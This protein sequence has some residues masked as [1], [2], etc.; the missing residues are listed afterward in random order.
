MNKPMITFGILG[1]GMI[2]DFHAR[3]IA[4]LPDATLR[5]VADHAPER[6]ANFAKSHGARAYEDYAAM[7]ADDAI[8][9]ICICTPSGHHAENA[10][11]ALRA[12]KHVVL[13]KPMALNAADAARVTAECKARGLFLTVISQ[14]RFSEDVQRIRALVGEGAFG[15][16]IFCGLS[17]KYWRD[18]DYY[19]NS[20]WKGTL[21]LDGGGALINQGI[22]GVDLMLH[23]MGDATVAG[24]D[25]RTL[26][27][28]IEAEDFCLALL[29]FDNGAL[30]RIEAASCAY[31]GFQR[32]LE[33]IG[34]EGCA[35]LRENRIEKLVVHGETVID[36]L[37]ADAADTSSD[38]A[39]MSAAP[40]AK[41]LQN[42]IDAIRGEAPLLV[43]ATEGERTVR[44]IDEIY[45]KGRV[46]R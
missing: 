36:G 2:A 35:I 9:V 11:A 22:H 34:S 5:G 32:S 15:K 45:Q 31:P 8:D 33:I 41:Q 44:L 19:A 20:P 46:P 18:P 37:C 24:A 42:L 26:F 29:E 38:P 14:L 17:M 30:G 40:H 39:A 4:M 27:H 21:A 7:L 12:G 10:I 28:K 25:C 13:E 6:A 23:I 43:D 16:P 3:A 1:C